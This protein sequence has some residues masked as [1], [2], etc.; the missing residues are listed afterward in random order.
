MSCGLQNE[1]EGTVGPTGWEKCGL[2]GWRKDL[3]AMETEKGVYVGAVVRQV[4]NMK[5]V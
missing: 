3:V 2:C 4:G 1:R 5:W